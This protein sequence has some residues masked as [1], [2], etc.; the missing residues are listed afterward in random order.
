MLLFSFFFFLDLTIFLP[1]RSVGFGNVDEK[2][3]RCWCYERCFFWSADVVAAVVLLLLCCC[4]CATLIMCLC[5]VLEVGN[6]HVV[7]FY[8]TDLTTFLPS[9]SVGFGNADEKGQRC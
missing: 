8:V 5:F 6:V 1:S 9:R 2:G 7:F 3:Q 4:S